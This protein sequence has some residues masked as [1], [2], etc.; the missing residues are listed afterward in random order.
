MAAQTVRRG[1]GRGARTRPP[2]SLADRYYNR[3][4]RG[5]AQFVPPGRCPVLLTADRSA[6]WVTSWPL[7]EYVRHAW[8]GA[9]VCSL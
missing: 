5:A 3:Q 2:G 8:P 1:A 6:V 7:A 9:W 4:A